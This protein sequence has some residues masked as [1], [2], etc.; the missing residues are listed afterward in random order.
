MGVS[1]QAV[2]K[3]EQ[4]KAVPRTSLLPKLARLCGC[5]VD[6]LLDDNELGGKAQ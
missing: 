2:G 6:E 3:W 5:T 4:G 1:Q